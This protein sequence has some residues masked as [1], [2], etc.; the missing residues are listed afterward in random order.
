MC[1]EIISDFGKKTAEK[2]KVTSKY[3]PTKMTFFSEVMTFIFIP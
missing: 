3:P 1:M 2:V